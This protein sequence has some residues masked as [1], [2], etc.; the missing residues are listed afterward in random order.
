MEATPLRKGE[1][2]RRAI[3]DAAYTLFLEQGYH[4]TSMRRI[5]E[6]A[7][8][9]LGGI[10]NHFSGKEEIFRAVLFD[11][12]PY[13][14]VISL[15]SNASGDDVETFVRNAA[16]IL[17]EELRER[18]DFIKL[19]FIEVVE[20]DGRH[21]QELF[22]TV[23]PQILPLIQRFSGDERL[24]PIPPLLLVRAFL[25]IF[26]AYLLTEA[27]FQ[28]VMSPE[29]RENALEHFVHIFLYGI[30]SEGRP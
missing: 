16:R 12:H 28:E 25:G 2:T 7:R 10:Y 5:A 9:A 30:L 23:F 18:P 3:M 27:T 14:R 4:A 17:T 20:F 29:M 19:A 22:R 26:I 1:R 21:L 13:R 8:I 15:I 11:R 24:V 6:R